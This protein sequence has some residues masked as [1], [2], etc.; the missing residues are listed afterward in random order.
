M[1]WIAQ[2]VTVIFVVFLSNTSFA[3]V[4]VCIEN[5][6]KYFRSD[7]CYGGI[8]PIATYHSTVKERPTPARQ[9]YARPYM[10]AKNSKGQARAGISQVLNYPSGIEPIYSNGSGLIGQQAVTRGS[11]DGTIMPG[12]EGGMIIGGSFN[13]SF[14]PGSKGGVVVG[15]PLHG[16]IWPGSEGGMVHGGPLNGSFVP[17]NQG[18]VIIGG[19]LDGSIWIGNQ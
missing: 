3:D 4:N 1:F 10:P 7:P 14:L 15:G 16:S 9:A 11:L 13:G 18:G 5:G 12:R 6:V 17:G 8:K 2:T 19:P